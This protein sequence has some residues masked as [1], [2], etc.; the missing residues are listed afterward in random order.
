MNEHN[1]VCIEL[2]PFNLIYNVKIRAFSADKI[3]VETLGQYN[4]QMPQ[5]YSHGDYFSIPL[6]DIY[7]VYRFS[8][9][10]E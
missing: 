3:L 2:K 8:Q 6:E 4:L 10:Q 9:E 5:I 7:E 1:L